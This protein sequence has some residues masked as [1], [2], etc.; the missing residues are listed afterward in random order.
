MSVIPELVS[1]LNQMSLQMSYLQNITSS[2]IIVPVQEQTLPN[3][4]SGSRRVY[5]DHPRLPTMEEFNFYGS[6]TAMGHNL[7]NEFVYECYGQDYS[8]SFHLIGPPG[9]FSVGV[10]DTWLDQSNN[11]Q[12]NIHFYLYLNRRGEPGNNHPISMYGAEH[13]T[14]FLGSND[15]FYIEYD[16]GAGDITVGSNVEIV[17]TRLSKNLNYVSPLMP[18]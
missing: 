9:T 10:T 15:S 16:N 3:P 12:N 4:D 13:K 11:P 18:I 17:V 14:F 6:Y 5:M 2:S 1:T 8:G 7:S